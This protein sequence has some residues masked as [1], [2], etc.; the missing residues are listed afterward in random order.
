MAAF[1]RIERLKQ[2]V[3]VYFA[4]INGQRMRVRH[5]IM[6]LEFVILLNPSALAMALLST[7]DGYLLEVKAAGV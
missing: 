4:I 5:P 6:S 3:S 2:S 1:M 7:R